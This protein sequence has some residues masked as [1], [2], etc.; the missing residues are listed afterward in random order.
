MQ[1]HHRSA[2][3]VGI[4][5]GLAAVLSL[6]GRPAAAELPPGA[7]TN[8]YG[9]IVNYTHPMVF[10]IQVA[11]AEVQS[12]FR[13]PRGTSRTHE[14]V[15]IIAAKMAPLVAVADG[16]ISFITIPE[17][18]WG[19]SLRLR[20]DD[21]WTYAYLHI[22]NDTP[23]TNDNN[24]SLEH[25]FAPGISLGAR[26]TAGQVLG[27]VGDSGY[28][29]GPHLHFE[30]RSPSGQL[31]DPGPSVKAAWANRSSSPTTVPPTTVPGTPTTVP[32]TPT[33]VPS[34]P[35]TTTR[36]T[37]T[38]APP[39]IV[40]PPLSPTAAPDPTSLP[41]RMAGLDRAQT[42]VI[43][44]NF[45]WPA[46]SPEVVLVDGT[47]FAE[48][49][50]ASVLAARRAAPVLIATNGIDEQLRNELARLG[51]TRV[52][53]VGSVPTS[54]DAEL[55][56]SGR[57]VQR[58]GVA[59]D[60]TATAA[61]IARTIGTP[62]G[63]IVLVNEER[64]ADAIAASSLAAQR[65]WPILLT[66]SSKIAQPTVDAWRAIG[67]RRTVI[68]GGTA[69][70][71]DNVA[72][73]A[74]GSTRLAGANRFETSAAAVNEALRLGARRDHVLV[75]TG[76]GFADA[77]SSGA[78]AA[79]LGV[80]TVLV[81]GSGAGGDPHSQMLLGAMAG[82]TTPH[83]FGGTAAIAPDAEQRIMRLLGR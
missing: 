51:A 34:A 54:V 44:S 55:I 68:V 43:A 30:M 47:R 41:M 22:N 5:L 31:A 32:T 79:R 2:T 36:P 64:F 1:R 14:G 52:W 35:T 82:G 77:I 62:D 80:P 6:I 37:T 72:R 75:V 4:A 60:A 58:I 24:A 21:G 33:T 11:K 29:S 25:V 10:P 78:L 19:Y 40:L 71:A 27:W 26:V 23:G 46:G 65:G 38:T 7:S 15:D 18:R 42:A 28:A 63:T 3:L 83:L 8:S 67:A 9:D 45:G 16:T 13:W 17:A 76:A 56:A 59:G 12:T 81:D 73:F 61:A 53:V 20:A 49:L 57:T 74:P 39:P 48:A 66:K 50:P 69:V 70:V